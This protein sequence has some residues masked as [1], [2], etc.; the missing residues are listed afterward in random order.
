MGVVAEAV[1]A[2]GI[3]GDLMSDAQGTSAQKN[4]DLD[5]TPAQGSTESN[6][7]STLVSK[8]ANKE[9]TAGGAAIAGGES[10]PQGGR[11]RPPVR[12]SRT[13]VRI[14]ALESLIP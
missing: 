12:E 7:T 1:A 10:A 13:A 4:G 14:E 2:D 5:V 3:V 11:A 6:A 8:A 9:D